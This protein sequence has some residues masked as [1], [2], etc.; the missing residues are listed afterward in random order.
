MK[1]DN[2]PELLSLLFKHIFHKNSQQRQHVASIY[3]K[4]SGTETGEP[5]S[6]QHEDDTSDVLHN[7][8]RHNV[9]VPDRGE[10]VPR[11]LGSEKQTWKESA[12][13]SNTF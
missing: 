10:S 1:Q 9:T 13:A 4:T 7:I 5:N 2:S 11:W 8:G 3:L 12:Q 6:D